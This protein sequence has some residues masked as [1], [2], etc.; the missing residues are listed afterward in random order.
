MS[1]GRPPGSIHL[2]RGL[3]IARGVPEPT[4]PGI[5]PLQ[6]AM[7]PCP[8]CPLHT[9]RVALCSAALLPPQNRIANPSYTRQLPSY[10]PLRISATI[11]SRSLTTYHAANPRRAGAILPTPRP[12][13]LT[14]TL[15][16]VGRPI[17]ANRRNVVL[18]ALPCTHDTVPSARVRNESSRLPHA[19]PAEDHL[20]WPNDKA[21]VSVDHPQPIDTIVRRRP[22]D[23]VAVALEAAPQAGDDGS[24]S[25]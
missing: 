12:T 11:A 6:S 20:L 25:Y 15:P 19:M 16:G 14:L 18:A 9:D 8:I 10:T 1:R 21:P 17:K 7:V 2:G 23:H 4:R 24:R 5:D 3:P 22:P 13:L